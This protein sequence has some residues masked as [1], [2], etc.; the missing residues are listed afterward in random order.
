MEVAR[1]LMTTAPTVKDY[2]H[3]LP[4]IAGALKEHTLMQS[5]WW[6]KLWD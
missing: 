2:R 5:L 4:R 6:V 1:S 3:L